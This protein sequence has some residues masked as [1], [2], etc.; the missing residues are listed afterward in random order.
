MSLRLGAVCAVVDDDGRVLLSKRGD[1]GVWSLPGGRLDPGERLQDAAERE[2]REETGIIVHVDRAVGLYYLVGWSRLN[3]LYAGIPIGGELQQRTPETRENLYFKLLD[4]PEMPLSVMA[5]DALA[6][7]RHKPRLIDSGHAE[8]RRIKGRLALRWLQNWLAGKR[9]PKFPVFDVQAVA[10]IWDDSHR[11][12]LTV[13]GE[14]S[15]RLPRVTCDGLMAP[16]EHLEKWADA[17]FGTAISYRW[18]G[19]HEDPL[20]AQIAFIFAASC[21]P[22]DVPDPLQWTSAR[23]IALEGADVEYVGRVKPGYATDPVWTLDVEADIVIEKR[24]L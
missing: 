23:S 11:R 19:L 5:L 14:R 3:V 7:T 2:I 4:L 20:R 22:D 10:V 1:L 15:R 17:Y 12:V 13:A 18:V 21:T 8:R 6:E 24:P 9:E 16:W